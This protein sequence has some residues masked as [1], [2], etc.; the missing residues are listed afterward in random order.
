MSA[1][2]DNVVRN[3][4]KQIFERIRETPPAE[5]IERQH[6]YIISEIR[7]R[8]KTATRNISKLDRELSAY[9]NEVIKV[10][11]GESGFTAETLTQLIN[12]CERKIS[13]YTAE[14][15]RSKSE[16]DESDSLF[17]E[18]KEEQTRIRSWAEIFDESSP[19]TQKMVTAS[20]ISA[21][22]VSRGYRMEIDLNLSV[23]EFAE[24]ISFNNEMLNVS[25]EN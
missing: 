1:K 6:E 9:K 19:E 7:S 16:L 12:D 2:I 17:E 22:R 8:I 20:L 23:K 21:V 18:T 24:G 14:L 11:Q 5:C 15:E 4:L 13:G 3:V 25:I 10:I